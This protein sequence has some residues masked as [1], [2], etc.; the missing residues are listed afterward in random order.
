MGSFK[1]IVEKKGRVCFGRFT[2]IRKTGVDKQL[3]SFSFSLSFS[4]SC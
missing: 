3:K 2:A 4:Y 1:R